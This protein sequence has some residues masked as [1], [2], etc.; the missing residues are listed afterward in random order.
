MVVFIGILTGAIARPI[1]RDEAVT[2]ATFPIKLPTISSLLKLNTLTIK[3][4]IDPLLLRSWEKYP[5]LGKSSKPS[6]ALVAHYYRC[7]RLCPQLE[8]KL[9]KG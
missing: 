6:I 2:I 4:S 7:L 5:D 8:D 3:Y 9:K 1:P